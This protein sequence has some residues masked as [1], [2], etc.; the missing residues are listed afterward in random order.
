MVALSSPA[1]SVSHGCQMASLPLMVHHI[2]N[3]HNFELCQLIKS[4]VQKF[5]SSP[6]DIKTS[7][8]VELTP[9]TSKELQSRVETGSVRGL[10][11]CY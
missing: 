4:K 9:L 7:N 1:H 6:C 10:F 11:R 8:T 3:I 5:T 2:H